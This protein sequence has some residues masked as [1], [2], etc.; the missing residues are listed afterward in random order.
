MIKRLIIL[1]IAIGVLVVLVTINKKSAEKSRASQLALDSSSKEGVKSFQVKSKSD[2][3]TVQFLTNQWVVASDSFPAD[4]AKVNKILDII[5]KLENKE[6]V[7]RNPERESEYGLDSA[8]RKQVILYNTNGGQMQ[9][10]WIGKTSSADYSSTYW[11]KPGSDPVYRTPG[12]FSWELDTKAFDWKDKKLFSFKKDA[13][14]QLKVS[15]QDTTGA[16]T[17]FTIKPKSDGN[18]EML[19]PKKGNAKK[20]LADVMAERFEQL[21]ID[22]FPSAGDS[23]ETSKPPTLDIQVMLSDGTSVSLVAQKGDSHTYMKHPNRKEIVKISNWRFN[24]FEKTIDALFEPLPEPK[25]SS[26]VSDTA[27]KP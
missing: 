9:Q 15:W 23:A 19:E 1:A 21:T 8:N 27:K 22:E 18:W 12:N 10:V 16:K 26:A 20:D 7:S 5:F 17:Q 3:V 4:T 25:D 13:V 11:K 14:A 6:I 2:S 24:V